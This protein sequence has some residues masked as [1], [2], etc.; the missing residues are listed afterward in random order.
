MT[1]CS[2]SVRPCL[3]LVPRQP[4]PR[5]LEVQISVADG[6]AP[7]GRFRPFR[8]TENDLRELVDVAQRLEARR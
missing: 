5:R 4:Q 8:I 6:R 2:Q 7:F 1:A 3:R